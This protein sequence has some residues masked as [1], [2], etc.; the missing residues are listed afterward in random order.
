VRTATSYI[1]VHCSASPAKMDIGIKEITEWHRERGFFTIGYHY[2]I[3]RDGTRERGRPLNEIGAHVVGH[4][5]HSVGVCLVGGV[6]GD[7]TLT[8]EDNFTSEQWTTL[9][10]TL[11]ELHEA[12]PKAVIVGHRDLDAGKACPSFDVSP[13]RCA[14]QQDY[15]L[16]SKWRSGRSALMRRERR[17][18]SRLNTR[19]SDHGSTIPT[20]NC[21]TESSSSARAGSGQP[22]GRSI[23]VSSFNDQS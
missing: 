2:V 10:L 9:Y 13:I 23:C 12:Y 11:K 3:R 5:H 8:P 15:A 4:N 14:E 20:S 16:A 19:R 6:S 17:R 18:S 7:G 22:I 21:P 1:C